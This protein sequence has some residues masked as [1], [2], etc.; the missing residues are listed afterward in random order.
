M[1]GS[2]FNG[3]ESHVEQKYGLHIWQKVIEES[4]LDNNGIYLAS[5]VYDDQD[6]F[7]L[8]TALSQ[9]IEITAEEIQREFGK[10]FFE[11]LFSLIKKH[12][13]VSKIDNL[14]DFLRA[15]D[16]VIHVEVK[17]ADAAAYTPAFFYDQ[18]Q[19]NTL[20]MRYVSKR[21]M[22]FFAEGLIA[23]AAVHF[24]TPASISQPKCIHCGDE[25]CL[26]TITI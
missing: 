26:I 5:E 2:V 15:V 21:G 7:H 12:A 24:K 20:V 25:Y 17:K 13:H 8:I 19:E 11:T 22:C 1:K 10:F 16:D 9:L 6:L 18:P 23:G 14:F 4:N 3:F